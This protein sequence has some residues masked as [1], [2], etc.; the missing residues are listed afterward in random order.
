MI[1]EEKK[2]PASVDALY[3][4]SEVA[5]LR[6]AC[7]YL[8]THDLAESNASAPFTVASIQRDL[9]Q[10]LDPRA[11]A[12]RTNGAQLLAELVDAGLLS[13]ADAEELRRVA[14]LVAK[15]CSPDV[16]PLLEVA[17]RVLAL[18]LAAGGCRG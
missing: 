18:R 17:R 8:V 10:A 12:G 13:E 7:I 9:V 15:E 1:G 2:N 14:T 4:I 11:H 6:N 5:M 16:D 3:R